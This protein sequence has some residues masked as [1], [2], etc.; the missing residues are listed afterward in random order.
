MNIKDKKKQVTKLFSNIHSEICTIA[1]NYEIEKEDKETSMSR[2]LAKHYDSPYVQRTDQPKRRKNL[3]TVDEWKKKEL[4]SGKS[5]IVDKGE[6]FDKAGIN[7]SKISGE[8]LPKSSVGNKDKSTKL[9]F[10]A[11]GV[12]VV[13]HPKNPNIP[14]AHFNIR[15]F[16]TL[17]NGEVFEE[18]FGGGYD[19][20]PYILYEEDC[21]QWHSGAKSACGPLYSKFKKNCDDYFYLKHRKEHRGI[22]GIF[23]DKEETKNWDFKDGLIFSEAVY[24]CFMNVYCEIMDRRKNLAFSARDYEFQRFRRGRYVEFNLIYDRGTL[25]GLQTG[26]RIESILMSLPNSVDW[27]YKFDENLTQKEKKLYEAIKNPKDWID[28]S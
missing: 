24:T 15:Y 3:F 12:S 1:T 23:Y 17:K 14:T 5:V 2:R 21:I 4:G 22:G 18:W 13:F 6:F 11:T 7:F 10:F 9:P 26:G 19:L 28:G 16:C 20:T 8:S 25:F 27:R